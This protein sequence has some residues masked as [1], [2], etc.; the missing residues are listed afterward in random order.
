MMKEADV[1]TVHTPLTDQTRG[2]V[3]TK[4]LAMMK[5][6]GYVLNCARGGIIDEDALYEALKNGKLAGAAMDVYE[7]EPPK[8]EK[9]RR[10][11]DLPNVV[12]TPHLGASTHEAQAK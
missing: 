4:E 8:D 12:C 7:K 2:I 11:I 5:D 9:E 10:L 6:G 3:G 1:L